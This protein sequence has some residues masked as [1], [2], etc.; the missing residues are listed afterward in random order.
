[1]KEDLLNQLRDRNLPIQDFRKGAGKLAEA[2]AEEVF[3]ESIHKDIILL[4]IL[5]S[6]I[7]LL[8]A[9]LKRFERAG[10]G[11]FGIRRNEKTALP[12]Q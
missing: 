1:M 12:Y 9:F 6:A 4:P 11:M 3:Q 10:V 2:I 8:P 5:R 7:V